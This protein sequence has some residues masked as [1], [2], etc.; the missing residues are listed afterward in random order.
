MPLAEPAP[1]LPSLDLLRSVGRL[2]S[3]RQAAIAHQI[4]Q[5]AASM[6]L[7]SLETLLGLDLLDRSNGRACLTAAGE[8]V[9]EWSD[10]VL[11][12]AGQFQMAVTAL[13]ARGATQLRVVASLTAAEY[14]IPPLLARLRAENPGAVVSLEVANSDQ[15][16]AVMR[17]H[18]ADLGFVEG[19][20][21]PAGLRWRVVKADPL[22][23]VVAPGHPWARRRSPVGG[24][25]LAATP[26]I[27]REPGSGTREVL[28]EAL[29]GVGT[30]LTPIL[31]LGSTTAIKAAVAC[32]TGPAVLGRLTTA[33]D[34]A[35]G[36]LVAV[37]VDGVTLDRFIRAV[38]PNDRSLSPL[39]RRVIRWAVAGR[40]AGDG[41]GGGPGFGR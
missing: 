34:V 36:R 26:L 35:E 17:R 18:D 10:A 37:P 1:S 38:W 8:A 14:L 21:A 7:R 40:E 20:R 13:R 22:V 41:P 2:G 12:A 32:G 3:I 11:E 9:V 15:V 27:L 16:V 24:A 25:E 33:A 29:R 23:L 31:E 19:P 6:R 39:A 5:P 28:D 30:G 4:S